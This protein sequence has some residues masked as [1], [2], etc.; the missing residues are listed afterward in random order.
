MVVLLLFEGMMYHIWWQ[1]CKRGRPRTTPAR[2]VFQRSASLA[3]LGWQEAWCVGEWSGCVLASIE[4]MGGGAEAV[5]KDWMR[6]VL[7]SLMPF[8]T[9]ARTVSA[10]DQSKSGNKNDHEKATELCKF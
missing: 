1:R 2:R 3:L 5:F 4:L 7:Q 9:F 6:F 8:L 10:S